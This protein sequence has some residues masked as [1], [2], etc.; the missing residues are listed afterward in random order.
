MIPEGRYKARGIEGAL[1]TTSKNN[2]QVAVLVEITEGEYAGQ[3]RTWYGHFTDKTEERTLESLR[4]LGWETDDLTDLRGIDAN[5]VSII[6]GHEEDERDGT[7]RERVRW[8][9]SGGSGLAMKER[10]DDAAARAFAARMKG[11]AVASRQKSGGGQRQQQA[12]QSQQREQS[13]GWGG[14]GG[15]GGGS[16]RGRNGDFGG[17][18]I[19][20]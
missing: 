10:M 16:T 7:M 11:A 2:P 14:G 4:H 19:P 12:P 15:G 18:G 5:E 20:F 3:Q 6:I 8:I 9:N 17:D 13:R 1:G